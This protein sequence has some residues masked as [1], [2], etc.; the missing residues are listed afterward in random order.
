M[1]RKTKMENKISKKAIIEKMK[2]NK[3]KLKEKGVKR[4]GI[5]GSY[6]K[7]KQTEKSDIDF[8]VEFENISADNF[9]GLLFLLERLFKKKIDL[10]EIKNLRNELKDVL[11]E[12]EYVE[13]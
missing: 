11:E 3:N 8:L 5:F 7:E 10:I 2:E 1:K 9:F 13:I 6:A 4:I 12:A